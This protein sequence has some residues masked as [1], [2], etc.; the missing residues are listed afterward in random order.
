MYEFVTETGVATAW[1]W[2][3]RQFPVRLRREE[4]TG[5]IVVELSHVKINA[6]LGEAL[7][8]V[9]DE[10]RLKGADAVDTLHLMKKRLWWDQ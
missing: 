6:R 3:D 9:P 10:V 5:P 8:R 2:H 1:V 4:Q 7:F